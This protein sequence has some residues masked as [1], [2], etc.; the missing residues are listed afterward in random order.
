MAKLQERVTL[1]YF[2][3]SQATFNIEIDTVK[4]AQILGRRARGA[5]TKRATGM[6]GSV[7]ITVNDD[8]REH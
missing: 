7:I 1:T 4:I 8:T 2:D 6:K 3:G 5:K